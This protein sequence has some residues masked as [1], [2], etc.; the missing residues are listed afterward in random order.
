M[1]APD[2]DEVELKLIAAD[3][4]PLDALSRAP[5]LGRAVLGPARTVSETDR[6]LDTPDGRLARARWACRLRRREGR[7]VV[8][9]KGPG[10]S[11]TPGSALHRRPEREGPA[12]DRPDPTS[13]PPSAARD[14]VATL[15]HGA[16]LVERFRLLQERTERAVSAGGRSVGT[17]SLDRVE[18]R[19]GGAHA[20]AFCIVELELAEDAAGDRKLVEALARSLSAVEG[21]R[22]DPRSKLERALELIGGSGAVVRRRDAAASDDP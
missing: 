7:I 9:L 17:L 20:G 10:G 19:H 2:H 14:L 8:S 22:P 12:S 16:P 13:W 18:V 4:G 5:T 3:A 6:Y 11:E 21:L 15:A 1:A